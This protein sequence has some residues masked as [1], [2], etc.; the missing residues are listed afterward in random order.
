M[1]VAVLSMLFSLTPYYG[2][3]YLIFIIIVAR[4][5]RIVR[6]FDSYFSN[7]ILTILILACSIMVAG[8]FTSYLQIPNYAII[9]LSL[10]ALICGTLLYLQPNRSTANTLRSFNPSDWTGIIAGVLLPIIVLV[11]QVSFQGLDSGLFRIATGDGWDS[12][13]HMNYL[14]VTAENNNYFYPTSPMHVDGEMLSSSYPQGWHLAS[15]NFINGLLPGAFNPEKIGLLATLI[16]YLVVI[17]SWYFIACYVLVKL[18]WSLLPK[19]KHNA[20]RGVLVFSVIQLPILMLYLSS[21][22]LGFVNYLALMPMVL[23]VCF[24][25]YEA[26]DS[27]SH[28]S[29]WPYV[30][31]A[32]L[33]TAGV[34][35]TWVLPAPALALLMVLTL[36][37]ANFSFKQGLSSQIR[38][39]VTSVIALL[40]LAIGLYGFLLLGEIGIDQLQAG[41]RWYNIPQ[42]PTAIFTGLAIAIVSYYSYHSDK[43]ILFVLQPF[44]IF[45]LAF[46]MY[47][48]LRTDSLGYYNAKLLGL[49]FIVV[50]A[51]GCA[52]MIEALESYQL[53]KQTY[54]ANITKA[55]LG[56]SVVALVLLLS[57]QTIDMKVLRRS[58]Y[59][60][61]SYELAQ[62]S[63]WASS[64]NHSSADQLFIARADISMHVNR[65][66]LF[67]HVDITAAAHYLTSGKDSVYT[68]LLNIHW[69]DKGQPVGEREVF[70]FLSAC[71]EKRDLAGLRT[72]IILPLS[73][74]SKFEKI[75][76]YNA[77]LVYYQLDS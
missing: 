67:N 3:A 68:C 48:Y 5:L 20:L 46:W 41:G 62:A 12:A 36:T 6:S 32:S 30:I 72:K 16:A 31:L 49:V 75:N 60:L 64:Q 23:L 11:V 4:H 63:K 59:H 39:V 47:T 27:S 13:P 17:F 8:I 65:A 76:T 18:V 66:M 74:K 40:L 52:L 57:N 2:A 44:L 53:H 1:I 69:D 70:K 24:M 14:Q 10:A 51:F 15:S 61:S 42:L 22:S 37:A 73:A 19:T 38:I 35:L 34:S 55:L 43:R 77:K 26:L 54:Y 56:C 45:I 25:S 33:L 29:G 21:L 9:N 28:K 7:F 50:S 58:Q 71:L